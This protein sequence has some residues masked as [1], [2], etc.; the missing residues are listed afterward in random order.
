MAGDAALES[1]P[2]F[3]ATLISL[4]DSDRVLLLVRALRF[5]LLVDAVSEHEVESVELNRLLLVCFR[6]ERVGREGEGAFPW[7]PS[8]EE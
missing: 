7:K 1:L 3:E 6:L 2:V 5:L 8:P 4:V